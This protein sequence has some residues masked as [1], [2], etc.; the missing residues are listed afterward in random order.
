MR[1]VAKAA[2]RAVATMAPCSGMPAAVR[3]TGLTARM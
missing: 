3:K 2:L 1:K